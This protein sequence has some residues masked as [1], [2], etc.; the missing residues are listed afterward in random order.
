MF[1]PHVSKSIVILPALG[2]LRVDSCAWADTCGIDFG[3]LHREYERLGWPASLALSAEDW[4][5][6][7]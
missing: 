1:S 4:P 5:P 3:G 6:D 2:R 7:G